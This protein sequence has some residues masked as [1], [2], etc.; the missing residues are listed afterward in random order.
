ML[1]ILKHLIITEAV[2][3][4]IAFLL[5]IRGKKNIIN[6]FVINMITNVPLN[7][8]LIFIVSNQVLY[9]SGYTGI[10]IFFWYYMIVAVLEFF[11]LFLEAIFYF[12]KIIF[13]EKC[14]FH[15]QKDKFYSYVF[16]SLILNISSIVVGIL[17]G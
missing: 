8:I 12:K 16:M 7:F 5:G 13:T 15:K 2:E 17:F 4:G 3:I 6:I 11:I 10:S 1:E 9:L 14:V